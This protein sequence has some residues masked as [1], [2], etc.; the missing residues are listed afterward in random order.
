MSTSSEG[1]VV[2][3]T[4]AARGIG[5]ASAERLAAT[6]S[7]VVISDVDL[8][9]AR[10][11]ADG[12]CDSGLRAE[13]RRCDV[14]R[15]DEI[16][17]LIDAVGA[18]HG[19]I[20][21]LVNNAGYYPQLDFAATTL[22]DF[23]R[24]FGIN[25]RGAFVATMAALPWMTELGGSIVFL[26]SGAGRLDAIEQP[27]A[28]S[29]PLYGAAKAA[30]DRWALG[31]AADLAQLDIAA[32]VL[33]PGAFVRT[34]GLS[35]LELSAEQQADTIGPEDVAPAVA[36]LAGVRVADRCGTLVKAVEFGR[37]WGPGLG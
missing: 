5:R 17:S 24:I 29:L 1:R 2:V 32:N 18:A 8:E 14:T 23:D 10:E 11:A 12:L 34:D 31:V 27:T 22:D 19:R 21:G 3:L 20:D 28:R 15:P 35:R 13:A 33:Y 30:L 25:M 36:Y 4:G 7:H 6:G 26:S 37:T 9:A 16:R